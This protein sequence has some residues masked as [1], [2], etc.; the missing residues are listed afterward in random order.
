MVT[1]EEL[2]FLKGHLSELSPNVVKQLKR[3]IVAEK[4]MK[5]W[6]LKRLKGRVDDSFASPMD[7]NRA[8]PGRHE[9]RTG[10]V[11]Q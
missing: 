9:A 5:Q 10:T 6:N 3:D 8:L 7:A 4:R 1:E 11:P 2:A